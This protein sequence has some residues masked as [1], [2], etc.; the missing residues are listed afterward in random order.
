MPSVG[1]LSCL[2]L[3]LLLALTCGD[4]DMYQVWPPFV[5]YPG[6]SE[7]A[8]TDLRAY[9]AAGNN[10][11]PVS[12][13]AMSRRA[14]M[15]AC[16]R[17]ESTRFRSLAGSALFVGGSCS[18]RPSAKCAT[19]RALA[20]GGLPRQLRGGAIYERRLRLPAHRRLP[21]RC[22]LCARVLV[23][24]RGG[25]VREGCESAPE[26]LWVRPG[27]EWLWVWVSVR[28]GLRLAPCDE[29]IVL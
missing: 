18:D 14:C 26:W 11:L 29:P 15:C 27:A 9:A 3:S 24:E 8:K 2:V 28:A 10:V 22:R 12:L 20:T 21:E 16:L 25:C 6:I 19:R 7:T 17:T 13:F 5:R 1:C 23:C 4:S